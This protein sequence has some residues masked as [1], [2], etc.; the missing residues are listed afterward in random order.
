ML[1]LKPYQSALIADP[2]CK[3]GTWE[4]IGNLFQINETSQK[5]GQ[6]PI[7]YHKS[8]FSPSRALLLSLTITLSY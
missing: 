7:P 5:Q 8:S 1:L 2:S 6:D 4:G 3:Q